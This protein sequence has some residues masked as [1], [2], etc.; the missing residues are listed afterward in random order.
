LALNS[1]ED[2]IKSKDEWRL[3]ANI[4]ATNITANEL[5]L[6]TYSTILGPGINDQLTK[7][8]LPYC[9]IIHQSNETHLTSNTKSLFGG[10]PAVPLE[11][12]PR[13]AGMVIFRSPPN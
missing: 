5:R 4:S 12:Y 10:M 13:A 2:A 1:L 3:L 8:F 6:N 11:P 9:Y 7:I